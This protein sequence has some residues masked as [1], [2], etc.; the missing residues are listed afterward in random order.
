[1]YCPFAPEYFLVYFL[2]LRGFSCVT[3]V[4]LLRQEMLGSLQ[5]LFK[6]CDC[7]NKILH[8]KLFHIVTMCF[9]LHSSVTT[10]LIFQYVDIFEEYNLVIL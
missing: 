2:T 6:F 5:I 4:Q 10:C 3:L 1:M 7:P 9:S 8:T